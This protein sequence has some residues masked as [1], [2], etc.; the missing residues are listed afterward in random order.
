ML[1]GYE[2]TLALGAAPSA[3]AMLLVT[4]RDTIALNV[5]LLRDRPKGFFPQ[6]DTGR[7][8]GTIQADQDISFQAMQAEADRVRRHRRARSGGRRT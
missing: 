2:R 6:Q 7:L 5:Y 1:R 4:A 3:A 8:I